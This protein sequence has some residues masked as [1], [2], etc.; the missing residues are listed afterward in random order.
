MLKGPT[1]HRPG[2]K[3]QG[4]PITYQNQVYPSYVPAEKKENIPFES[5]PIYVPDT[6][7]TD[8]VYVPAVTRTNIPPQYYS[9]GTFMGF[10][11][12]TMIVVG[13]LAAVGFVLYNKR[14]VQKLEFATPLPIHARDGTGPHGKGMGPGDGQG[15][16]K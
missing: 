11:Y 4:E 16:Q 5:Q 8:G 14:K 1:I 7:Q 12:G 6:A 10:G 2:I 13:L 9:A 15:C 3:F